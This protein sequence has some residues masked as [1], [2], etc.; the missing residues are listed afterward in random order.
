MVTMNK[1]FRKLV[2]L[3]SEAVL[4]LTKHLQKLND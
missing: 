2:G 1:G 3:K 4:N